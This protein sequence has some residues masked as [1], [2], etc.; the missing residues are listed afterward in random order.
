[1]S[2]S[3]IDLGNKTINIKQV[4][5]VVLSFVNLFYSLISFV[6][7]FEYLEMYIKGTTWRLEYHDVWLDVIYMM[8]GLIVFIY[9]LVSIIKYF[10]HQEIKLIYTFLLFLCPFVISGLAL[11]I[12]YFKIIF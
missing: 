5:A 9:S 8:F 7:I 12:V 3:N 6:I 2:L 11:L 4:V 10:K 1:M